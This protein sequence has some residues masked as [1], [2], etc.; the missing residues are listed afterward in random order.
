VP[1]L[2]AAG[3]LGHSHRSPPVG[4]AAGFV[5]IPNLISIARL[6]LVPLIVWLIVA[7]QPH[8]AFW[9]FVVA[10]ISDAVDGFIARTFDL[11]SDLGTYLD[12]IA[13]KALLVSIYISLAYIEAIPAWLAILVVSRD[14]LIIGAVVLSWMLGEPMGTKPHWVS[15]TNTVL[16]IAFAALVLGDLAFALELVTLR[17]VMV[18]AVGALTVVSGAVYLVDWVRHMAGGEAASAPGL[19]PKD[20]GEGRQDKPAKSET[21]DQ[22]GSGGSR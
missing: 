5:T 1:F 7:G 15:K 6:L 2:G 14:L 18:Y 12:P 10:G 9:V 17:T 16:Q 19:V 11:R 20:R 21:P 8:L 3:G 4:K 13:D 22:D